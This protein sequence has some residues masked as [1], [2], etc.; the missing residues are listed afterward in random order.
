MKNTYCSYAIFKASSVQSPKIKVLY[1]ISL[2]II[3]Y[4]T[5]H[6]HEIYIQYASRV[7]ILSYIIQF[8]TGKKSSTI[9]LTFF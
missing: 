2:K 1:F 5:Q 6:V 9:G 4:V 7:S 3:A 8:N